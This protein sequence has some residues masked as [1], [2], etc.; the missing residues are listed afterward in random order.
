MKKIP[1]DI[2]YR[3][4]IES[5]QVKVVTADNRPVTICRWD[6]KGHYPILACLMVK[7]CDWDGEESWD[8]ELHIRFTSFG[9]VNGGVIDDSRNLFLLIEAPEST[10]LEQVLAGILL[11]REYEGT[12]ETEEEADKAYEYYLEEAKKIAPKLLAAIK[13]S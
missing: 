9:C 13:K 4:Q 2:K 8:D 7:Q 10:E 6:L 11:Q 12:L 1:F 3:S 5:G